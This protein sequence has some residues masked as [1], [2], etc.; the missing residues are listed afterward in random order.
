VSGLTVATYNVY[1]GAD[2]ALLFGAT[3]IDDLAARADVVRGQL[4]HT[5][6]AQRADA[7]ARILVRE[8][9]DVVGLQEVTRWESAPVGTDGAIGEPAVLVDFLPLLV[10]ACA[11]AGAAYDVHA[12]NP[13]F[14]GGLPVGDSWMSILGANVV[15]VRRDGA[16]TVTAERTGTFARTLEMPTGI[17]GVT[18]PV[19]RGWGWVEGEVDGRPL[20]FVNTHTEAYDAGVR[21]AQRDELLALVADHGRPV[22]LVGDLNARPDD[23]GVPP[24]YADAWLAVGGDPTAGHTCGQAAE[25]DNE[26]SALAERIDY[27]FVR[28]A[29]VT[30]CAVVGGEPDDRTVPDGLWPSDH[31]GVVARLEF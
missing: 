20:L 29:R 6:F 11:A 10:E 30:A 26:R 5:D 12:V 28:D 9:V 19:A 3:S 15:L 25:L 23:V 31:A 4:D 22:V 17:A 13:N 8:G 16:F 24:P 2:L 1:L 27:V 21:D 18:F 14:A 7:I